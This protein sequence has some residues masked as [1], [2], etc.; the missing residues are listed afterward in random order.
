MIATR[1][2]VIGLLSGAA[3]WPITA[4]AQQSPAAPRLCVLAP[5]SPSSPWGARYAGF[6]EG[7]RDLGY[8]AGRN[9]LIDLLSTDGRPERFP[10]LADEC[11][12]LR[13][14]IIVA[15][16][17]PGGLAAKKATTTIPIVVGP[18]GDPVATGLVAGLGRPGGN[19]TALTVMGPELSGKRLQLFKETIPTLGLIAVLSQLADP[20]GPLQVRELEEAAKPMGLRLEVYDVKTTDDLAPAFEM[21]AK[22]GAQGL[23]TTLETF[24]IVRRAR[25]A[26]LAAQYRLPAMFTVRDFPEAGGLMSYGPSTLSLYRQSAAQV[27]KILKGAKPADLPVEQPTKFEFIINLKTAKTLGL[28]ISPAVLAHTD[29]VIE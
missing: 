16:T 29:E 4:V 1:R 17:T 19:I 23:L 12:K 21:A 5:D 10:A 11:I 2:E 3:A 6:I 7:L 24:F 8:L 22:S 18:V 25:I 28:S 27:D 9:I 20:I 26:E 13:P 14:D 15:Y